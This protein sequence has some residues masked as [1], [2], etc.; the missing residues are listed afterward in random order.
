MKDFLLDALVEVVGHRAH[1]HALRQRGN[2]ARGYQ[3]LHLRV[4][5]GGLVLPVDGDALPLLQDFAETLGKRFGGLTNDLTRKD[6]SHRVHHDRRFFV[7]IIAFQ[8]RKVLK[9]EADRHLVASGSGDKIIQS[10]EVNRRQLVDDY[11]RLQLALL[12][13]E[14]DN[15]G[16][17]QTQ[18]RAVDVLTVGIIADAENLRLIRV[19]NI[20]RKLTV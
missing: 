20:Q 19:V 14:L 10:L 13:N 9:A 16:I 8:L 7:P 18:R 2:L 11:R 3:A 12:V 15:S 1:E 6:V 5:G 4:D 17:V